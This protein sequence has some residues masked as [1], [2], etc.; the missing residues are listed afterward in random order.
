MASG[1]TRSALRRLRWVVPLTAAAGL[2]Q[3]CW[4][5]QYACPAIYGSPQLWVQPALSPGSDA[6][7][8]PGTLTIATTG[9]EFLSGCDRWTAK[10]ISFYANAVLIGTDDAAPFA[11]TWEMVP[12]TAPVPIVGEEAPVTLS[13]E[14]DRGTYAGPPVTLRIRSVASHAPSEAVPGNTQ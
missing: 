12:G 10:R 4:G 7:L 3:A 9:A 6:Y 5:G 11:V 2:L 14:A 8:A 13:Y 1:R